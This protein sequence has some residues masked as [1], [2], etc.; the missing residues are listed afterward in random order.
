MTRVNKVLSPLQSNCFVILQMIAVKR[1]GMEKT[2][3][4]MVGHEEVEAGSILTAE[5][6]CLG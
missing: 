6:R 2:T 1:V 4:D 5:V 3:E